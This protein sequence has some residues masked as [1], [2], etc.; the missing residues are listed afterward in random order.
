MEKSVTINGTEYYINTNPKNRWFAEIYQINR[1]TA[2]DPVAKAFQEVTG[3][4]VS[5]PTKYVINDEE[6]YKVA[7]IIGSSFSK[8]KKWQRLYD[9]AERHM[10]RKNLVSN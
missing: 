3:K 9:V 1:E 5:V 8:S 4:V 10:F 7:F 6:T 2:T